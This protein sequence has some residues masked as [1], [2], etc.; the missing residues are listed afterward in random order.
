MWQGGVVNMEDHEVEMVEDM[1]SSMW[2]MTKNDN[3]VA[4]E[5]IVTWLRRE[6]CER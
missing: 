5:R 2:T 6:W 4:S 3:N 1:A